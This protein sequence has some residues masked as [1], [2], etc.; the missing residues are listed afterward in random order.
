MY[1]EVFN[2]FM[3]L[4]K[5]FMK[6]HGFTTRGNN[7]YKHHPQGNIGIINFQKGPNLLGAFYINVS[8]YSH[9]LAEAFLVKIGNNKVKKYPSE[10][11]G[12]WRSRI[13]SL[14][15]EKSPYHPK[16]SPYFSKIGG[17][18][19]YDENTNVELFFHEISHLIAEFAIPAIDQ[20]ITDE[21]KKP[22]VCHFS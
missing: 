20:R 19:E 15:P 14:V 7:F 5:P 3:K 18:W 8:V 1:K 22:L 10:W 16:R 6:L 2:Q 12:H 4:M 21:Q 17:R 11:D 9:V 13:E